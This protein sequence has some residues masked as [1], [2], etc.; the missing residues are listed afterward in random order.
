MDAFA[1]P[2]LE[3]LKLAVAIYSLR[4]KRDVASARRGLFGE[5]GWDILLDLYIA[6]RR[7]TEVQVSSV[8]L[9]AGVPSTTILRW[10]ARLEQEGLIYRIADNA[11][12]RRRYVRLTEDGHEMMRNVLRAISGTALVT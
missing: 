8:C 12:A 7:R 10:I 5:P 4:R 9:D 6:D 11:D 2:E 1:D 3:S